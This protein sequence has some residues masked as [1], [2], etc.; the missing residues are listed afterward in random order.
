MADKADKIQTTAVAP[1][2]IL[3]MGDA[4]NY[5]RCLAEGLRRLGHEAVVASDGTR[6]MNTERDIDLSRPLPGKAGGF[7]LWF[8]IKRLLSRKFSD[9]DI[10]SVNGT[11]FA[12][13]RP[14][15]LRILFNHLLSHNKSVFVSVLGTDTHYV[16]A[17]TGDNPPLRYDEWQINGKPSDYARASREEAKQWL[18]PELSALCRDV[19]ARSVGAVTALYE[20]H[21]VY[22]TAVPDDRLAYGGIPIDTASIDYVGA[23]TAGRKVRLFLGRHAERSLEKGTDRLLAAARRVVDAHP[24]ACT[25]DIVEN[26]P[27]ADYLKRLQEADV[28][29]DQLYSYTPATNALLGMARGM[30]VV[31]GAEPEYYD[32]IGERINRPIINAVPDDAVLTD[33]LRTIVSQPDMIPR[34]AES[35][36]RFVTQ[37]NSTDAVAGRF[38]DFW[39]RRLNML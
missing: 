13:L 7:L 19:Y 32:F 27:Y 9:Y 16:R 28:V 29:L 30:T 20:Y 34:R 38:A 17:C 23:N 25:L 6:W 4:S 2:R 24:E 14:E 26:I 35:G 1:L 36:R 12:S 3:L 5:H 15:R 8:I 10:V 39:M 31:T 18:A 33:Q 21:K 11:N 22:Q 37:H